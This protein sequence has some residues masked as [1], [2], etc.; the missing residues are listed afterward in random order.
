M[1]IIEVP[2]DRLEAVNKTFDNEMTV[3]IDGI[4]VIR[5]FSSLIPTGNL[6]KNN[7]MS[8]SGDIVIKNYTKQLSDLFDK[9]GLKQ[10]PE[11]FLME[12]A[13]RMPG[14]EAIEEYLTTPDPKI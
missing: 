3:C 5:A 9:A 1:T 8:G 2:R 11:D 12:T 14:I 4:E 10:I 6:R 13:N 7:L